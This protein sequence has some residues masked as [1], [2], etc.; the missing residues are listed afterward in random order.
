MLYRTLSNCSDTIKVS[1]IIL[2]LTQGKLKSLEAS[3]RIAILK[4]ISL[5]ITLSCS[6]KSKLRALFEG[7]EPE[8]TPSTII[9]IKDLSIEIKNLI[10]K[11]YS[12]RLISRLDESSKLI[13]IIIQLKENLKIKPK[14]ESLEDNIKITVSDYADKSSGKIADKSKI[15]T[16]QTLKTPT[17]LEPLPLSVQQKNSKFAK[18]TTLNLSLIGVIIIAGIFSF[19]FL[20]GVF[21]FI[22][23]LSFKE[24]NNHIN[25]KNINKN[26]DM[27]DK[28]LK[29]TKI[30]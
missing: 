17:S 5:E 8:N 28:T 21:S 30:L 7:K 29:A 10:L 13:K 27:L 6:N 24:L 12:L 23:L 26:R 25:R 16:K 20:G 11:S 19:C 4:K 1:P 2:Y 9:D 15:N 18:S 22:N 3:T 14:S